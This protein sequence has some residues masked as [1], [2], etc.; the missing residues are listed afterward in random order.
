MALARMVMRDPGRLKAPA[1][2]L[3]AY[4]GARRMYPPGR[5]GLL[6]RRHL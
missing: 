5:P 1:Y 4:A 6:A 2:R 3:L